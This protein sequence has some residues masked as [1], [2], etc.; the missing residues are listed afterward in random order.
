VQGYYKR[1]DTF[2]RQ[3]HEQTKTAVDTE[4]WLQRWV[5]GVADRREYIRQLGKDRVDALR[6]KQHAYAAPADF[7]Y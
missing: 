7:G 5:Y 2:F 6:V 4:A 1:D 3:Y